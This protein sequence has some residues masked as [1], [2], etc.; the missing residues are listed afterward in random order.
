[1][2]DIRGRHAD[3]GLQ[4]ASIRAMTAS[5]RRQAYKRSAQSLSPRTNRSSSTL[6]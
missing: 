3:I 4:K 6:S 5:P 1:M 2:F